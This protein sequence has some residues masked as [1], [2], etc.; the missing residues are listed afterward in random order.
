MK[1]QSLTHDDILNFLP[2]RPANSHK[3]MYG[4]ILLLC[5]SRGYTGAAALAA[6]GALR[7]GAGLVYLAVPESIY[8]I[9][10]TKLTEPVIFPLADAG[11]TYSA[12]AVAQVI[13][14]LQGKDAVLLG[15]GMGRS[16]GAESVLCAVLENY[17]GPVIVDADGITLL[18]KHKDLLRGRTS[19]TILTPHDGE[20]TRI[21]GVIKKDRVAAAAELANELGIILLLKGNRTVITDGTH[22]F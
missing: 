16:E 21:G 6:M 19:P 5:G 12:E 11:G 10:A 20:F 13:S 18:S 17:S 9:E 4:K 15:P 22:H 7:S 1:V 2:E 3:G 8:E 14:L